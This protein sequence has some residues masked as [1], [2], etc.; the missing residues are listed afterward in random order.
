MEERLSRTEKK[1]DDV[2]KHI[3]T[4]ETNTTDTTVAAQRQPCQLSRFPVQEAT[5]VSENNDDRGDGDPKG[6][7]AESFR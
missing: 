1:L 4:P 5:L 6:G 2:V 3:S 7:A